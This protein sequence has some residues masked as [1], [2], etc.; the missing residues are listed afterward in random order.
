MGSDPGW[1]NPEPISHF[2]ALEE[3]CNVAPI[4]WLPI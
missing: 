4:E 1:L 3:I 2:F